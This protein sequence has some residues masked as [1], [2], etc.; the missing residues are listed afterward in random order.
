MSPVA[1]SVELERPGVKALQPVPAT[2]MASASHRAACRRAMNRKLLADEGGR[3]RTT[4]SPGRLSA[5]DCP[6]RCPPAT[7]QYWLA[8]IT[9]PL[10]RAPSAHQTFCATEVL[11]NRMLPSPMQALTPPGW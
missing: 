11:K 5:V 9:S 1:S 3:R 8:E 2:Q 6:L 7:D 10:A 4:G